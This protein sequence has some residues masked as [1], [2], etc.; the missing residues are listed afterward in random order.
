MLSRCAFCLSKRAVNTSIARLKLCS[1]SGITR[2]KFCGRL[3]LTQS[4]CKPNTHLLATA[5]SC[6]RNSLACSFK[7]LSFSKA[8]KSSAKVLRNCCSCVCSSAQR[9]SINACSAAGNSACCAHKRFKLSNSV[10]NAVSVKLSG[11]VSS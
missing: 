2:R 11:L 1:K 9:L 10:S 7:A 4:L 6:R 3:A 8:F 5:L